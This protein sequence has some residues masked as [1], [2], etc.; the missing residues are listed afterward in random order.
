[1]QNSLTVQIHNK[2][3]FHHEGFSAISK[4]FAYDEW[5]I[6]KNFEHL[7][8]QGGFIMVFFILRHNFFFSNAAIRIP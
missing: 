8:E 1:M 5:K 3:Q 6:S 2:D 4:K 7:G